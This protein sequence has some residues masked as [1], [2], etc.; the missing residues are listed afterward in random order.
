MIKNVT[1]SI[2][3]LI[4]VSGILGPEASLAQCTYFV[5]K[6]SPQDGPGTSWEIK[7]VR[8]RCVRF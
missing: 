2:L 6:N 8:N 7:G 1:R 3:A 5:D 4:C